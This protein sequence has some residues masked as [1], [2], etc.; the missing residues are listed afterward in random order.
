MFNADHGYYWFVA[1]IKFSL[2]L[3]ATDFIWI[4]TKPRLFTDFQE[5]F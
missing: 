2:F 3:E 5:V 1:I 4:K